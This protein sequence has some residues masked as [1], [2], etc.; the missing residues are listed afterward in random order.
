[1]VEARL[2]QRLRSEQQT[3][4]LEALKNPSDKTEFAFG[5]RCGCLHGLNRAEEI[6]LSLLDEEK[7]GGPDL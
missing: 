7:N 6:L 3:F 4:A 5:W 1:M 2:L